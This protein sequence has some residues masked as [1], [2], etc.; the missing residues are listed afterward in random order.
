MLEWIVGVVFVGL[1][2][3]GNLWIERH[4][5]YRRNAAG[6]EVF[7]TFNA[8]VSTRGGEGLVLLAAR[9]IGVVGLAALVL[10]AVRTFVL[11]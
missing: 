10:A 2:L 11:A 8:S 4:R 1:S 7:R 5:F 3:V 6:L 9:L